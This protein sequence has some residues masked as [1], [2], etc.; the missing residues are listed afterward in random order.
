M[1]MFDAVS[2]TCW[3]GS[4]R[5]YFNHGAERSLSV[6][7]RDLGD[8]FHTLRACSASGFFAHLQHCLQIH[9]VK[10]NCFA[11]FS[12]DMSCLHPCAVSFCPSLF[13]NMPLECTP[14]VD[15]DTFGRCSL[16]GSVWFNWLKSRSACSAD[17]TNTLISPVVLV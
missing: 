17:L 13:G 11:I 16:C 7:V 8:S 6:L 2:I 4:L 15:V 10:H 3:S 14:C 9:T 12:L 1:S 5:V